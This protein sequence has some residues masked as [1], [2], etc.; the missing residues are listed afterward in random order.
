MGF[1]VKTVFE[2]LY[3]CIRACLAWLELK[4]I[5]VCLDE[6]IL[7]WIGLEKGKNISLNP[8]QY[9]WI[10]ENSLVPKQDLKGIGSFTIPSNPLQT[11][12]WEGI[13]EQTLIRFRPRLGA[14]ESH[15]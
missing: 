10:G 13:T 5:E 8:S 3:V 7:I 14:P 6:Y 11:P 12:F 9:I 4:R 15:V 2:A 1:D